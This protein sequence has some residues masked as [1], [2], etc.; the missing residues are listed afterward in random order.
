MTDG[1]PS[2][3]EK[4]E[5]TLTYEQSCGEYTF[6]ETAENIILTPKG[7]HKYTL[8]WLHG[9]GHAVRKYGVQVFIDSK[10]HLPPNVKIILPKAPEG[11]SWYPV[12]GEN[13]EYWF[14]CNNPENC[15]DPED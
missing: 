5:A 9:F 7:E 8:I 10:D 14:D 15:N 2:I 12:N 6:E 13:F 4:P 3:E 11:G 1:G